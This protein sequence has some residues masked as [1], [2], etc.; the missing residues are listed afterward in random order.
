VGK[1]NGPVLG[2]QKQNKRPIG[3]SLSNN[4]EFRSKG[5]HKNTKHNLGGKETENLREKRCIVKKGGGGKVCQVRRDLRENYKLS[6]WSNFVLP[7]GERIK[8]EVGLPKS[9]KLGNTDKVWEK[10]TGPEG[11]S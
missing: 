8:P 1:N 3:E 9:S 4:I 6:K 7:V 11:G 10:K 5:M 2:G